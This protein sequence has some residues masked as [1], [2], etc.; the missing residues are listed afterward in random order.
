MRVKNHWANLETIWYKMLL[1]WPSTNIAQINLFHWKIWPPV[2]GASFSYI[3][4]RKVAKIR[5][6]YNQVPHLTQDTTW[7]TDKNTKV[8]KRHKQEPRGQPFPGWWPQ[9]AVNRSESMTNTRHKYCNTND[10]QKRYRL[11]MVSKNYL[12]GWLKPVSRRQPHP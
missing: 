8:T 5:N 3:K 4:V 6:Q 9:A 11:G 1:W 2:R 12:T 7:E 10:P